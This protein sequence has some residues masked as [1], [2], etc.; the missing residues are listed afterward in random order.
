M[1]PLLPPS[2]DPLVARALAAGERAWRRSAL[3]RARQLLT[4]A[5]ARANACRDRAPPPRASRAPRGA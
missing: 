1:E 3:P 4:L 2:S 5:L